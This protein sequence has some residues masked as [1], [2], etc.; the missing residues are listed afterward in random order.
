MRKS[1]D[2][3]IVNC[4]AAVE[5]KGG[6]VKSARICLNAVYSNPYR[7]IQAEEAIKGK[8]INEAN[9]EAA[10]DAAVTNAVALPYNRFK[11]QIAKTLVKRTILACDG[12][13]NQE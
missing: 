12:V 3:A 2:F 13:Q 8:P 9:A 7:V 4:A 10:G 5:S 11:I 6:I 1:I